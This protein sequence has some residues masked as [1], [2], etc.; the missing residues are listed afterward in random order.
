M[1]QK[2]LAS[3]AF[4]VLVVFVQVG[5]SLRQMEQIVN[6]PVPSV[7]VEIVTVP[8]VVTEERF[9]IMNVDQIM[10]APIPQTMSTRWLQ[11]Q[12]MLSL[13]S[14][15]I[16][17]MV[18]VGV[19][20][21]SAWCVNL[22]LLLWDLVPST[23]TLCMVG[24]V[25]LMLP[26]VLGMPFYLVFVTRLGETRSIAAGWNSILGNAAIKKTI[27]VHTSVMKAVRHPA[28]RN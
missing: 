2:G 14:F 25:L 7:V 28:A 13:S 1:P 6:V 12:S 4:R 24:I 23:L 17:P 3:E 9:I 8:K 19:L 11:R 10:A 26:P 21:I 16:L 5:N 22:I 20:V 15:L 27:G 18:S